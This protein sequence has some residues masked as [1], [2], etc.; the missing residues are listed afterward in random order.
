[1]IKPI[2]PT[3]EHPQGGFWVKAVVRCKSDGKSIKKERS[4]WAEDFSNKSDLKR[5]ASKLEADLFEQAREA[6]DNYDKGIKAKKNDVW[7]L[8]AVAE[9]RIK[10]YGDTS[11]G[12][13]F[14]SIIDLCGKALPGDF[15]SVYWSTIKYLRE[16]PYVKQGSTKE[17]TRTESTINRYRSVFRLIFNHARQIRVLPDDTTIT[18]N[19]DYGF[20][21]EEGRD[22]VWSPEEKSRIFAEM[23]KSNSWL[24]MAVYFASINPIRAGD[25]FGDEK[26]G[27]PGLRKS[28]W[29]PGKNWVEFLASKTGRGKKTSKEKKRPTFLKQIDDKLRNYFNSLPQ[30]CDMLFQRITKDGFGYPVKCYKNEWERICKEAKVPDF[31][32][33][34]LKHC[35]ITFLL[36]HGYSELDLENCGIQF[37]KE[38][39]KRY[40][41]YDATKA[42]VISGFE[43]PELKVFKKEA[44]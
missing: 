23:E 14:K 2:Q 3:S 30:N 8:K 21:T 38:M 20:D 4:L 18:D 13:Y 39:I 17:V 5:A 33:H 41:H 6:A 10:K 43:K 19:F 36:D 16:T 12:T 34:D 27:N 24:S 44:V 26:R 28:N 35:A 42:P 22:R 1:M 31:H 32:F 9:D 29:N 40:Y 25:L 11:M 15:E 7:T 37:S